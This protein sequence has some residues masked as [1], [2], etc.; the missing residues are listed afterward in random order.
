MDSTKQLAQE[1][2]MLLILTNVP[3]GE[4]YGMKSTQKLDKN[5]HI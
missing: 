2:S 3:L 1:T 4:M 5:V